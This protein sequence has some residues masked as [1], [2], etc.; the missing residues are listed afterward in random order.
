M[1]QCNDLLVSLRRV[2]RAIDLYSKKLSKETGLTSP[3]LLV[4]HQ[5]QA[6]DGVL[7]SHIADAINLS[8]ATVTSILDRLESRGFVTRERSK[9]DKRKVMLHLTAQGESAL[10]ESPQPLQAHFIRRFE[11]LEQWEQTM[12]IA[13]MQRVANMMDAD[14]LDASPL[15]Q[16]GSIQT[17]AY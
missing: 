14:E 12:I 6:T 1:E 3:Q 11:H 15:L 10:L 5:I 16:V 7:A 4:L 8:S 2:I 17:R 9:E 13:S